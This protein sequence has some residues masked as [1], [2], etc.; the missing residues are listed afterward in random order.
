[1]AKQFGEETMYNFRKI[2]IGGL[3]SLFLPAA[4]L[5]QQAAGPAIVTMSLSSTSFEDGGI[6]PTK[7][8][9]VNPTAPAPQL[10]WSG[11]PATTQSFVVYA[12]D[13]QADPFPSITHMHWGFL[14]IPASVHSLAEGTPMVVNLPDGSIQLINAHNTV[15]WASPAAG[16]TIYHLYV[17]EIYALN[18]KL[19]LDAKAT[20]DDLTNAMK[21][22]IVGKGAEVALYHAP[23]AAPATAAAPAAK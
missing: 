20:A 23:A 22:H 16:G 17:F 5:A 10:S 6:L 21:G 18:T 4:A 8:A 3:I 2:A 11:E 19:T 12:H 7:Y 13:V 15:G 9:A 14:N 1:V